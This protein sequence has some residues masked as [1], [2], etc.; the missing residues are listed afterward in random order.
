MVPTRAALARVSRIKFS[1]LDTV[2]ITTGLLRVER[3][4]LVRRSILIVFLKGLRSEGLYYRRLV[5]SSRPRDE[6]ETEKYLRLVRLRCG[7]R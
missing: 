3:V 1:G 7:Q 6:C 4:F 5:E 2:G